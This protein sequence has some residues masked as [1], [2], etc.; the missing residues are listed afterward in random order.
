MDIGLSAEG[1]AAIDCSITVIEPGEVKKILKP[2]NPF[3]HKGSM[4]HALLVS[5]QYGMGG[6]T[7]LAAKACLRS[8][9][10][11]LTV[12]TPDMNN[13]I[14]QCSVPE[15]ILSHDL[16]DIRVSKAISTYDYNALAMGPGLGTHEE[17]A[18]ALRTFIRNHPGEMVLDAE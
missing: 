5:G 14:L 17:T 8:G 3:A 15:A 18:E 7:I 9:V 11:K 12:H 10:G 6:A 1:L 2:R 16:S 13:N 4:G